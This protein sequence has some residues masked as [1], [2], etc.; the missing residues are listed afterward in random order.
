MANQSRNAALRCNQ[1]Q[2]G[3]AVIHVAQVQDHFMKARD[4]T[5]EELG[6]L[7]LSAMQRG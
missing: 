4:A 5:Q 3:A 2:V 7:T 6:S 1:E